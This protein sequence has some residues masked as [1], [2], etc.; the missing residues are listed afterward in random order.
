VSNVDDLVAAVAADPST[1]EELVAYED[2]GAFAWRLAQ[3]APGYGLAVTRE[4]LLDALA[5]R[6]REWFSR[7]V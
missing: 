3:L 1:W 7:W 6:R 4:E 5:E 2:R